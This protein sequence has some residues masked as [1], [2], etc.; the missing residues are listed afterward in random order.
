VRSIV[1]LSR[2]RLASRDEE[3][4]ALDRGYQRVHE[5][6]AGES[7]RSR[8]QPEI[9]G[10][11]LKAILAEVEI[12][13]SVAKLEGDAIFLYL[14]KDDD[15]GSAS[16]RAVSSKLL[17]FFDAFSCTLRDL[18]T[19][20]TCTCGACR[21][22]DQLRLKVI[23]HAGTALVW[24][25]AGRT[26]LAGVDVIVAHRLLKNSVAAHEYILVTEAASRDVALDLPIIGAGAEEYG[27]VGTVNLTAYSVLST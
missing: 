1:S 4:T 25:I 12:P 16:A 6:H 22:V 11:L 21:N 24:S 15:G 27:D 20:R 5:V 14:I 18:A 2:D 19:S 7:N 8:A 10:A 26:E 3:R 17:R 9:I 23:V 13:L